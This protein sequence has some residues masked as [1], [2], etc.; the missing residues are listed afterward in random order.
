MTETKHLSKRLLSILLAVCMALA[1]IP[2]QTSIRA[3]AASDDQIILKAG[4]DS[5][6]TGW[7]FDGSNNRLTLENA[8]L[9]YSGSSS[10]F[11][12]ECPSAYIILKGYNCIELG[13]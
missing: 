4:I 6:G 12:F 9:Y 10:L 3:S 7:T 13:T 1:F 2:L 5:E 11:Y 8:D